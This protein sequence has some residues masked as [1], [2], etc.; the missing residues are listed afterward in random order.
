MLQVLCN[1]GRRD[2]LI[3][4]IL[5]ETTTLGVRFYKSRRRILWRDQLDIETSYGKVSVKRV[6]DI[7]G[8]IRIIPEFGICQKI[9][10]ELDLPL[11]VVYDTVAR[12]AA[13]RNDE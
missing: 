10:R 12:D 6:K 2:K 13:I 4:R 3:R 8:N 9:A 11:R 5:S 1:I 7:Q